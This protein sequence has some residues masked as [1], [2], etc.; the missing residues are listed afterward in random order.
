MPFN[1]LLAYAVAVGLA[2][3][4]VNPTD[5]AGRDNLEVPLVLAQSNGP[6]CRT[7]G[8][9]TGLDP[10]GDGFLSVLAAPHAHIGKSTGYITGR[11]SLSAMIAGLG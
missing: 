7:S 11:G 6:A 5:A 1:R 9:I 2:F 8:V 10:K 3:W 4:G